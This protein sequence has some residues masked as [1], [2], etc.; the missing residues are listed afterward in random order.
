MTATTEVV[1]TLARAAL[2]GDRGA[3]CRAAEHA[4]AAREWSLLVAIVEVAL[5]CCE[6]WVEDI[7]VANPELLR[8]TVLAT[9]M[10][11]DLLVRV[12]STRVWRALARRFDTPT[13][14]PVSMERFG[15]EVEVARD[16]LRGAVLAESNPRVRVVLARW[17]VEVE[18]WT[19]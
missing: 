17:S 18:E 14:L 7:V 10:L 5:D 19:S 12:P 16:E 2:S 8:E 15:G 1:R 13:P 11:I 4:S 9:T 6:P 3:L